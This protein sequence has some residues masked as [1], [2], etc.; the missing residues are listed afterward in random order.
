VFFSSEMYKRI[1]AI[2]PR[3]TIFIA[4]KP[5]KKEGDVSAKVHNILLMFF[6]D[7]FFLVLSSSGYIDRKLMFWSKLFA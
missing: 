7:F 4:R 3:N 6:L 1:K 5:K 2:K